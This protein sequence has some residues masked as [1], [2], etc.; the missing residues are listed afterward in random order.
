MQPE[1]LLRLLDRGDGVPRR[2]LGVAIELHQ[3]LFGQPVEV[4][5]RR[6]DPLAPE[7][8]DRLLAHAVD[9]PDPV[10]ERLE[11]ARLAP[12]IG[13]AVHRLALGLDDLFPAQRAF[14]GHL[15]PLRPAPVREHRTDNL[16]D[17]I[18]RALDDHVVALA[19]VLAVDVLLVV[20]RRGG[21]GHAADLNRLERAH[22]LSAPVRPTRIWILLS[23]V[24]A[25]IG[26]HLKA[27]AQRGRPCR[28]AR[29]RCWSTES[30]LIT[31]PSIS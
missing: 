2:D 4:G 10:D 1:V 5:H 21:D 24:C 12:R 18:A 16:W 3:L 13:A 15:E 19:D 29:R 30:T 22:G 11:T 28:S 7:P 17:H 14:F 27:R 9:V 25:V 20:E 6:D 26:A 23:L 8:A 31:I